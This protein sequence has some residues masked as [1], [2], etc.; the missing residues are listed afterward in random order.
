MITISF[1][2]PLSICFVILGVSSVCS[3]SA[4]K[5]IVSIVSFCAVSAV[6]GPQA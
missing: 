1:M 2:Y 5:G 4:M 3:I 6:Q